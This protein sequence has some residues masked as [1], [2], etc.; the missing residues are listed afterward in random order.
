MACLKAE[1]VIVEFGH[2]QSGPVRILDK[3]CLTVHAGSILGLTGP[4]GTGKTTLGRVMAGLIQP[5]YGLVTCDGFSVGNVRGRSGRTVQGRIGMMFQ[6]P[7]RSCN[8]KLTLGKTIRQVAQPDVD[9]DELIAS[10]GLTRDLLERYP[11]QVSDGQLQ[12]AA[13]ART[14]AA[15]PNYIILDEMSAMLDP[16]TTATVVNAVR[17]FVANGGGALLISHDH[18]LVGAVADEVRNL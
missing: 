12:R 6:S 14:V 9:V 13:M 11:A 8:P 15:K 2:S 10:V 17:R 1:N 18:E 4:S 5:S 7:R 16:A 3:V